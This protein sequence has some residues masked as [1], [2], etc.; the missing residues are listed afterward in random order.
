MTGIYVSSLSDTSSEGEKTPPVL[1][2][3]GAQGFTLSPSLLTHLLAMHRDQ[4]VPV[5]N[6]EKGLILYQPRQETREEPMDVD[7]FTS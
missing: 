3:P 2:Q 5:V 1:S 7:D 4:V 6:Q